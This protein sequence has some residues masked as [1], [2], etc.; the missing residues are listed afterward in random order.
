MKRRLAAAA[1]IGL[2]ASMTI[3]A[4]GSSSSSTSGSSGGKTTIK[5]VAADYGTGASNTSQTYWQNV[6]A[7]FT[8]QNPNITVDVQTIDWNDL[9]S[10]VQTMVQNKQYPDILEGLTYAQYVQDGI[11]YKASDVLD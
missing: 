7:D 10:K 2:S 11:A 5:I 3:A 1:V 9:S 4:C 8:K 6:A